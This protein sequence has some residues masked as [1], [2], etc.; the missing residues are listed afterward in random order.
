MLRVQT[1]IHSIKVALLA[2]RGVVEYDPNVWDPDKIISVSVLPEFKSGAGVPGTSLWL[3]TC[4]DHLLG[5]IRY[6]LR[7]DSHPYDWVRHHSASHIWHDMF[8]V[9]VYSRERAWSYAR[10]LKRIRLIGH[11]FE[12][13]RSLRL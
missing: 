11:A 10:G 9:H 4:A 6:W 7:C 12:S 8:V 3:G 5:N 13:R 2:E 1:G